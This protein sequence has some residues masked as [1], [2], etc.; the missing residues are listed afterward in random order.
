M[1]LAQ[2][3]HTAAPPQ[4]VTGWFDTELLSYDNLPH[5]TDRIELTD[6]QWANRF[7]TPFVNNGELVAAPA[8]TDEAL[9]AVRKQAKIN[10]ITAAFDA[11]IKAGFTTTTG[12][13]MNADI[14]DVQRLKSAF[15]LALLASQTA[16]PVVVDYD[17]AL[18]ENMA[19]TDVQPLILE[20]GVNYET[21]YIKKNTLRSLTM[22]AADQTELDLITWS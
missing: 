5:T 7:A 12:I 20:L 21:L 2:Y 17:N 8:P 15:D 10:E 9:L 16:L 3:D 11:A 6:E 22:A 14:T 19:L 1:K 18:H 13:K 4:Q